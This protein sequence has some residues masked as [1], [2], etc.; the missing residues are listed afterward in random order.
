MTNK[1]LLEKILNHCKERQALWIG[2]SSF[3]T[4]N[5]TQGKF[6]DAALN[7]YK[8]VDALARTDTYGSMIDYLNCLMKEVKEEEDFLHS[9]MNHCDEELRCLHAAD[10][11]DFED[12]P[13]AFWEFDESRIMDAYIDIHDLIAKHLGEETYEEN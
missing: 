1:E 11:Y 10:P 3:N 5:D 8:V 9:L 2:L 4:E 6:S 7:Q 13:D 12:D